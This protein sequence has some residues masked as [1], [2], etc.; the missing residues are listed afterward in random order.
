MVARLRPIKANVQNLARDR[1]AKP[2][3][4]MQ[5]RAVADRRQAWIGQARISSALPPLDRG[6]HDPRLADN[7]AVARE[8]HANRDLVVVM[9]RTPTGG[10]ARRDAMDARNQRPRLDALCWRAERQRE[11]NS[12]PSVSGKRVRCC[13]IE[14]TAGINFICVDPRSSLRSEAKQ[15]RGT[16]GRPTFSGLLRRCRS[17]ND[18]PLERHAPQALR[19]SGSAGS[20]RILDVFTS[21]SARS[22]P[23][24]PAQRSNSQRR[25]FRQHRLRLRLLPAPRSA[26][27]G[28]RRT[29]RPRSS[30]AAAT[31]AAAQTSMPPIWPSNKSPGSIDCRRT[32]ASKLRPPGDKP[33]RLQDEIESRDKFGRVVG[34]LVGVPAR[35]IVIAVGVERTQHAERHGERDLMLEGMVRQHRMADLDVELDLP[36]GARSAAGSERRSQRQNRIDAWS[37]PGASVRPGSR[38]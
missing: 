1:R 30:C 2:G 31:S 25:P 5:R 29:C 33:P 27:C 9:R 13:G 17:A 11:N 19:Y 6:E 7:G 4:E 23:W 26:R 35:L 3:R 15:S 12:D 18:D 38:P 22:S 24:R 14:G 32:L 21:A 28:L 34:K 8:A 37:A 36:L 20:R 16:S 10:E